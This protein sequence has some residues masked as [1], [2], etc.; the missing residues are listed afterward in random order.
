MLLA[1]S[2]W[3]T[4]SQRHHRPD[5]GGGAVHAIQGTLIQAAV[6]AAISVPIGHLHRDLPRGVRPRP[7]CARVSFMVDI[8]TGV[9]SI[10]A[11][12]FVY[13]VWVTTFGFQRIRLRCV[14]GAWCC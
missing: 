5:A 4:L 3:W 1:S 11:A 7:A 10:V 14:S 13:A 12:L 2:D 6:T 9:P 8:L